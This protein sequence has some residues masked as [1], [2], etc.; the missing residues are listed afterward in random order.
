M[1]I[2]RSF[3]DFLFKMKGSYRFSMGGINFIGNPEHRRFWRSVNTK[4]WEPN[5]VTILDKCLTSESVYC[6]IG[7]WVGPTVLFAAKKARQVYC[8][9]PDT[10]AFKYL[11]ENIQRNHLNNVLPLNI[12]LASTNGT[13]QMGSFYKT[14]GDST[15]SLLGGNDKTNSINVMTMSWDTWLDWTKVKKIDAMKIDIEGGEF[16]F[17]PSMHTYLLQNKPTL[18][19]S[20]HAPY[21]DQEKRLPALE[22]ILEVVESYEYCYNEKLENIPASEVLSETSQNEFVALVF[23]DSPIV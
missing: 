15:A 7:A 18:Y 11:V 4:A 5:T 19:L 8:F 12:A 6:D 22:R 13:Q 1:H 3:K 23:S 14:L 2:G 9:E 17:L 21:L 20:L 10:Y 16:D